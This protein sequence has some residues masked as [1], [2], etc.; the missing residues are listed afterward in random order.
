MAVI[1]RSSNHL[2]DR[3]RLL[4]YLCIPEPQNPEAFSFQPRGPLRITFRLFRV[5]SAVHLDAEPLSQTDEVDDVWPQGLLAPKLVPTE[6]PQTQMTPQ[7]AFSV[8]RM[9]PQLAGGGV[10]H[11]PHPH[12]PPQ[13]GKELKPRAPLPEIR[14][15]RVLV[16]A[17]ETPH[18]LLEVQAEVVAPFVDGQVLGLRHNRERLGG[19]APQTP[20]QIINGTPQDNLYLPNQSI[21]LPE[22]ST[23]TL[24]IWV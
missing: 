9:L 7:Q 2:F 23:H 3:H 5:L 12:L 15:E 6:L 13:G 16:V 10:L 1:Q 14:P 11:T 21:G 24:L 19:F 8:G 20:Y 22:R 4:Q 17:R 18:H